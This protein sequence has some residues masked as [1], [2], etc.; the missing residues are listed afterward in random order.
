MRPKALAERLR[1]DAVQI[2]LLSRALT[3]LA[4]LL[5]L[6]VVD[7][8][9]GPYAA[10][11]DVPGLTHDLG[12]LTDVWARWDSVPYLAIAEHGYGG[13]KGSPAF[14][15]LYPWL[16]GGL[17]RVLGG[18]Y[19]LAGILVS[20][21]ATAAAFV[22]L[23]RLVAGR[24]GPDE[25][26]A[27]VLFLAVFPMS[28][29]L[30]SVYAES[31]LLCLALATFLAAER[32]RYLAAGAF[33]GLAFLTKPTAFALVPPLLLF[34]WRSRSRLRAFASLLVAPVLFCA[35][36]IVLDR[37]FGDA[38]AFTHAEGFWHRKVSP[39]GPLAGIWDGAHAAWAG[40]LQLTVGSDTH[41]Y[42]TPVNPSRAAVLNIE[43]FVYLVV[44][45]ALTVVAWRTVGATYGLF[46]A[47]SLAITLSAPSDTYPL[48]SFPRLA[49]VIFP[50][51][52]AAARLWG[53]GRAQT[54]VCTVCAVLLGVAVTQW[55]TWQ[56]VS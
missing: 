38:W 40:I 33:A 34:A 3:W 15:P 53:S 18:H 50:C 9:R 25:R 20:L 28:L 30:Q 36:P 35:Y 13:V 16:V 27:A 31:L 29:F 8:N 37:Q 49:L 19:V 1:D 54:V 51:F 22:L 14:Y 4:A 5:A 39:A 23:D 6:F 42:W 2:F 47:A 41:W 11:L 44:F 12:S 43:Y 7:P 52:I 26:R 10:R 45:V 46:A 55:A 48:L 56:W 21:A 17:G 24:L 32:G